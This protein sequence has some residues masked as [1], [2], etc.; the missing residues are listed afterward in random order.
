MANIIGIEFDLIGIRLWQKRLNGKSKGIGETTER[1]TTL[2][3][4]LA[5]GAGKGTRTFRE[6]ENQIR[7]SPHVQD[8]F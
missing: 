4:R 7:N 1:G 2:H 3:G 8:I 5:M 6:V